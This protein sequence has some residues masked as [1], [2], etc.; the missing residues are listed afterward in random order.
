VQDT[1]FQKK[2]HRIAIILALCGLLFHGA[3]FAQTSEPPNYDDPFYK[4]K[5][6]DQVIEE[7]RLAPFQQVQEHT[8]NVNLL[9]TDMLEN[10]DRLENGD[11][12]S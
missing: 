8:G 12:L 11:R 3:A 6:T 4:Q 1:L 5:G 2:T 9:H 7:H 10:E